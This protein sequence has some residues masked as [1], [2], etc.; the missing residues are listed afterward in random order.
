M[1]EF[2]VFSLNEP[3]RSPP[4]PLPNQ[5]PPQYPG[6]LEASRAGG[7]V[8]SVFMVD[9]AGRV[10]PRTIR[11]LLPQGRPIPAGDAYAHQLFAGSV[12]SWLKNFRFRPARVGTC[13]VKQVVQ[14]PLRFAEPGTRE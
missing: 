7:I 2:A 5:P 6:E 12:K 9:T 1:H 13:A 8:V 4:Q 11:D 14:L 3:E 10:E